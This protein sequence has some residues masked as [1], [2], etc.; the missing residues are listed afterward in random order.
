MSETLSIAN[1]IAATEGKPP[2][3]ILDYMQG[4]ARDPHVDRRLAVSAVSDAALQWCRGTGATTLMISST[5][6]VS[7]SNTD[8][9]KGRDLV[10]TAK[11]SGDIEFD[12]S[13]VLFAEMESCPLDGCASGQIHVSKSRFGTVGWVPV[14][15]EGATGLFQLDASGLDPLER[16]ILSAIR[17]GH[18]S[19]NAIQEATKKQRKKV[20]ATLEDMRE[21][22]IIDAKNHII[23]D[24]R[25]EPRQNSENAARL[26]ETSSQSGSGAGTTLTFPSLTG[27]SGTGTAPCGFGTGSHPLKGEPGTTSGTTEDFD[28]PDDGEEVAV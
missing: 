15:F 26:P 4:A 11:E 16:S 28:T 2:F 23:D 19:A 1:A 5:A 10:G 8:A 21:R 14:R 24:E 22:N 6:R 20:L 12:C 13:A 3:L 17:A 27:G 9:K 18:H 25:Q 7:Y